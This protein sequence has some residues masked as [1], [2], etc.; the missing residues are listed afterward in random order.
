MIGFIMAVEKDSEFDWHGVWMEI[1]SMYVVNLFNNG[2]SEI[3]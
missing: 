1:D 3:P 2:I